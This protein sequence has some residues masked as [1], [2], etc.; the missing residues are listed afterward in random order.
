[1]RSKF[2]VCRDAGNGYFVVTFVAR[3]DV[4]VF[5]NR[6]GLLYKYVVFSRRME[7]TGHPHEYLYGAP[8]GN[9]FTNRMLKVPVNKCQPG[10]SKHMRMCVF[11]LICSFFL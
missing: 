6:N 5:K 2:V 9:Q 8:S 10:G 11:I 7:E 3:M 4:N 1:M